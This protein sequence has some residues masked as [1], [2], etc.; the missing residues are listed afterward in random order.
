MALPADAVV[1]TV[2]GSLEEVPDNFSTSGEQTGWLVKAH[3]T[4]P[5]VD[6]PYTGGWLFPKRHRALAERLVR[7]INAGVVFYDQQVV[8][9]VNG[10]TFVQA[11]SRVYGKR[12]NADLKRL[13]F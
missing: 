3:W 4:S 12:A 2:R 8:T 7:A 6:R 9:D 5:D 11:W 1:F 10:K 13:G